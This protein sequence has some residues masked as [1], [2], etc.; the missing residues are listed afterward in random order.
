MAV[1]WEV[2][3][4]G[5]DKIPTI[6]RC[7]RRQQQKQN[8]NV[9]NNNDNHHD[10][11]DA[12]ANS[13]NWNRRRRHRRQL[14]RSP[15][16]HGAGATTETTPHYQ[17]LLS[18]TPGRQHTESSE[19]G[20]PASLTASLMANRHQSIA[21]TQTLRLSFVQKQHKTNTKDNGNHTT[22]VPEC[23]QKAP[24]FCSVDC[25]PQMIRGL[26]QG[27]RGDEDLSLPSERLHTYP[28][29]SSIRSLN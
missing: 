16:N 18:G 4:M 8:T 23:R 14:Q 15:E 5:T 6:I 26:R 12:T 10:N 2:K 28:R 27:S 20:E 19:T 11:H 1:G 24:D 29:A 17:L 22:A 7:Q 21:I 9:S 13:N 3:Y 25:L